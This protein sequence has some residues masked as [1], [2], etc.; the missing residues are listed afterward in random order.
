M[1]VIVHSY[2]IVINGRIMQHAPGLAAVLEISGK[3]ILRT[4][5]T[6]KINDKTIYLP[7]LGSWNT[8]YS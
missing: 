2:G 3:E 4:D 6:W 8:I 7:S 1:G 5:A